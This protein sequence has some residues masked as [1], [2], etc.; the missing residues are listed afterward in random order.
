MFRLSF[1]GRI[2][3]KKETTPPELKKVFK[4]LDIML[5]DDNEQNIMLSQI[6]P[7]IFID[8]M[9]AGGY[10]DVV[11]NA[12][13][14]FGKCTTNPIPVNGQLG[15][16][17]YLSR[18][19]TLTGE[20]IFFHR[21]GSIDSIDIFEIVSQSGS[22]WDILYVDLY[23]TKKTKLTPSGYQFQFK[24]ML[25]RGVT[26]YVEK[27]PQSFYEILC[28]EA[29]TFFGIPIVADPDV[30]RIVNLQ[31]PVEQYEKIKKFYLDNG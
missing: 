12:H 1:W 13:G 22:V 5:N 28:Q 31:R 24:T 25:I 6:L 30:K 20:K 9:N 17:T 8:K 3:G 21:L 23:H 7:S 15:E 2:F 29:L 4:K 14:D 27:F 10:V 26:D 16:I 18:L 19:L 11:P